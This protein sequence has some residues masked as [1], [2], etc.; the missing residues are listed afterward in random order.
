MVISH[1]RITSYTPDDGEQ[2][3]P[4]QDEEMVEK[5]VS[6]FENHL[7]SA[8]QRHFSVFSNVNFPVIMTCFVHIWI[9]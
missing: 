8:F 7:P 3:L 1:V 6:D 9:L 2:D 5:T 4:K